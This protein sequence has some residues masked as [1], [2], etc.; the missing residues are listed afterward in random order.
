MSG[1]LGEF[2]CPIIL[3]HYPASEYWL[4]RLVRFGFDLEKRRKATGELSLKAG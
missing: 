3:E 1:F 2:V 4:C